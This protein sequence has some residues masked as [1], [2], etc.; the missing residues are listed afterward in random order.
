MP[1][2]EGRPAQ[3]IQPVLQKFDAGLPGGAGRPTQPNLLQAGGERR[4]NTLSGGAVMSPL[5][6]NLVGLMEQ[7]QQ[8]RERRGL[9]T[10]FYPQFWMYDKIVEVAGDYSPS[11]RR[12]V[13]SEEG[14]RSLREEGINPDNINTRDEISDAGL[15]ERQ[16][17]FSDI[18]TAYGIAAYDQ[19]TPRQKNRFREILRNDITVLNI[20]DVTLNEHQRIVLSQIATTTNTPID[21]TQETYHYYTILQQPNITEKEMEQD[22]R[23]NTW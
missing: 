14:S 22:P 4:Q 7:A 19:F 16:Q 15:E 13:Q 1:N 20:G 18:A 11:W 2:I 10:E 8:A 6:A 17:F 3:P 12:Y 5:V 9:F 21:P 23:Y